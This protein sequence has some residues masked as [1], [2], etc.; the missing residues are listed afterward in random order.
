MI[1]FKQLT[2]IV[3]HPAKRVLW[4]AVTN[5]SEELKF[6]VLFHCNR[7]ITRVDMNKRKYVWMMIVQFNTKYTDQ[8]G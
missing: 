4:R 7:I 2:I 6:L 1:H 3:S 8:E 5:E